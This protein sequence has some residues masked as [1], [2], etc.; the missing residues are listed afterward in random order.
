MLC[1]LI[2]LAFWIFSLILR[3]FCSRDSFCPTASVSC[4]IVSWN[5][6]WS[7]SLAKASWLTYWIGAA[8]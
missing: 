2:Y 6:P 7:I 3:S 8:A 1:C 5:L 4:Y